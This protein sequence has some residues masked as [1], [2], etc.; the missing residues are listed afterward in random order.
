MACFSFESCG[1]MIT[2]VK[3]IIPA[4]DWSLRLLSRETW[5]LPI[6]FTW[7][8]R[9]RSLGLESD[10]RKNWQW[11]R[12]WAKSWGLSSNIED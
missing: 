9:I 6:F 4:C 12:I 5:D 1:E 11:S 10:K 2:S 3:K 8:I 7:K